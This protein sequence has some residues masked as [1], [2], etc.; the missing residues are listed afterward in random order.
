MPRWGEGHSWGGR[1]PT[2]GPPSLAGGGGG[3][4]QHP[5]PCWLVPEGAEHNGHKDQS[6]EL[7]GH[8]VTKVYRN[9]GE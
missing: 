9:E 4:D 3:R 6:A 2:M 5:G 8:W 7:S 1:P